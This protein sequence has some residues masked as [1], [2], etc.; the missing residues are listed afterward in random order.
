VQHDEADYEP[1]SR[2]TPVSGLASPQ[3]SLSQHRLESTSRLKCFAGQS[4]SDTSACGS[5]TSES[6]LVL[7]N[8]KQVTVYWC[9]AS[10][11]DASALLVKGIQLKVYWCFAS[12]SAT[13]A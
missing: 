2:T 12:E 1:P 6:V 9:F 13:S 7:V 3:Q 11:S 10:E 8:V 5:D 4:G